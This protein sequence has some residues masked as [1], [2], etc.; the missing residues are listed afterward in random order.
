[1]SLN[2]VRFITFGFDHHHEINGVK[3]DHNCIAVIKGTREDIFKLF[4]KEFSM[5][6]PKDHWS[7]NTLMDI[8]YKDGYKLIY[9][10]P[11]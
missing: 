10:I 8:F 4:N 1:M 2:T 9:P 3:F 6:Y 5:E 11:E 7:S